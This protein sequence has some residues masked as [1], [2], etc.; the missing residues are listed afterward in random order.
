VLAINLGELG[1]KLE[2]SNNLITIRDG[3]KTF[4]LPTEELL[5]IGWTQAYTLVQ[6]VRMASMA[7]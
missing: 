4:G 2:K 3:I 6:A 5:K 7:E 1:M